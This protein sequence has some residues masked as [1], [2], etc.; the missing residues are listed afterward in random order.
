MIDV[1]ALRRAIEQCPDGHAAI[2]TKRWLQQVDRDMVELA[3]LRRQRGLT[4]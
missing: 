1:T 2:V 4:A 3:K